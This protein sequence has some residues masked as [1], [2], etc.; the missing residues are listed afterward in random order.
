MDDVQLISSRYLGVRVRSHNALL[1]HVRLTG[2]GLYVN[3]GTGGWQ[4]GGR[5]GLFLRGVYIV[6][7]GF[8]RNRLWWRVWYAGV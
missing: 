8:Y 5:H 4:D 2:S 1:R 3:Q 6:L 7:V